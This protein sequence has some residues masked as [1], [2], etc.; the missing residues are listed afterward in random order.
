MVDHGRAPYASRARSQPTSESSNRSELSE[1][2]LAAVCSA[3]VVAKASLRMSHIALGIKKV[4][5]NTRSTSVTAH[6]AT[7]KARTGAVLVSA[8]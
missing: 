4:N 6:A 2:H 7:Q 8:K 3:L 5:V 1:R